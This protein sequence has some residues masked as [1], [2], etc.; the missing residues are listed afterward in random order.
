MDSQSTPSNLSL[1]DE[2]EEIR[3]RHMQIT[4]ELN[5][6]RR[7]RRRNILNSLLLFL[8]ISTN[9]VLMTEMLILI[10][11]LLTWPN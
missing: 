1:H 6:N 10:I 3:T 2:I 11:L 5:E 9:F 4:R 7:H 8:L